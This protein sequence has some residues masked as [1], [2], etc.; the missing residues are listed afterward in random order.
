MFG[1]ITEHDVLPAHPCGSYGRIFFSRL[2]NI[3]SCGYAPFS[4][5]PSFCRQLFP[6]LDCC[7]LCCSEHGGTGVSSDPDFNC[8]DRDSEVGLWGEW[9]QMLLPAMY[10]FGQ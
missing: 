6:W 3:P 4:L 1:Y 8:L 5:F 9:V 10:R 2:E 7:E